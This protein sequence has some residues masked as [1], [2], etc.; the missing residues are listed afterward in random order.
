MLQHHLV[1]AYGGEGGGGLELEAHVFLAL[2]HRI[3]FP[4]R[5][6]LKTGEPLVMSWHSS[7]HSEK[8]WYATL[9]W[10]MTTALLVSNLIVLIGN[11]NNKIS[12]F[13]VVCTC[14]C[15]EEVLGS[16][17]NQNTDSPTLQSRGKSNITKFS[18]SRPRSLPPTLFP[19]CHSK[20]SSHLYAIL[21]KTCHLKEC[22]QINR[23]GNVNVPN[24]FQFMASLGIRPAVWRVRNV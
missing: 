5:I 8:G 7:L 17:L 12:W 15:N 16:P 2:P 11:L 24:N 23:H 20:S 4:L 21:T 14:V 3:D 1:E 6:R 9:K 13:W 10:T 22:L 18:Y 19:H